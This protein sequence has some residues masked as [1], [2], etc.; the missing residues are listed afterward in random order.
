MTFVKRG[1]YLLSRICVTIHIP[2]VIAG[3]RK[4]RDVTNVSDSG[5]VD[6]FIAARFTKVSIGSCMANMKK[7]TPESAAEPRM[8]PFSMDCPIRLNVNIVPAM[9][10]ILS[11]GSR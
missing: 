10:P 1:K 4:Y 7:L 11:R 2:I 9:N 8:V 3:A 6:N 5:A